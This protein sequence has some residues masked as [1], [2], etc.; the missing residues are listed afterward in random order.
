MRV[1]HE[2]KL[3]G[4]VVLQMEGLRRLKEPTSLAL[5]TAELCTSQEAEQRA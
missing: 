4:H 1:P 5:E 2:P 3:H